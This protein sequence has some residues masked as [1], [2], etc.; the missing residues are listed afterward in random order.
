MKKIYVTGADGMLGSAL[1]PLFSTAYDV[2]G[3][4]L[5][6]FDIT[7]SEAIKEDI[8]SYSPDIVIH[9]ASMTD[10]DRC[11]SDPVTARR[12]NSDG[13]E[14]VAIACADCDATM[15]YI[16]TGM[17]YN[18]HKPGPYIEYDTPDP[19]NKYG[20]T[21]YEGELAVRKHLKSFYIFNTCWIFGGG[22]EDKKF[23]AKIIELGRERDRL[24]VVDDTFGS[25]TYTVDLSS[26]LFD[27]L[28][29]DELGARY[30]RYHCA[31]RGCVNRLGLAREIF[32]AAG[33]EDCELVP[34]SSERFDLPAPRPRMEALSNYSLDLLGLHLMRDWRA[35]LH[36]YVTST[37]I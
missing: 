12:I 37:L 22:P 2:R 25:P 3:T 35:A 19:V 32:S 4:D 20:L 14:N 13:T 10:V 29:N 28:G 36:E 5:P 34:V 31:G 17:S 8:T 26:A 9:L 27:F 23:V 15:I 16:S 7:D 1:V 21:K 24:E 33:I 18:G 30:G 11:E 6:E